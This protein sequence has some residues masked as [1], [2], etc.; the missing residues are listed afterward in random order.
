ML[1]GGWTLAA[2]RQTSFDAC[3]QSISAL[4]ALDARER[5]IMTYALIGLGTCHMASALGLSAARWPGRV[6]LALGGLC[7][8]LVAAFPLA[9][10][11]DGRAHVLAASAAFFCLAVWP[12]FALHS[13]A[14]TPCALRPRYATMASLTLLGLLAWLGWALAH[15]SYV[16]LAERVAAAAQASWP[17]LVAISVRRNLAS[18]PSSHAQA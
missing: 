16:G 17:L 1:V 13:A 14:N 6:T 10:H 9:P 4:A 12:L 8:W 18:Q 3:V 2:A 15:Q 5:W 7:T 11:A